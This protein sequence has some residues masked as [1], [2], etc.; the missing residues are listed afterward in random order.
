MKDLLQGRFLGHPLHPLLVHFPIALFLLSL[1]LDAV[2]ILIDSNSAWVQAAFW[3]LAFGVGM[4]LLASVPGWIDFLDI[5]GDHPA[6]RLASTH[7]ILNL[8][9]VGLYS[10]SLGFRAATLQASQ[11]PWLPFGLSMVAFGLIAYSGHLGGKMI[12]DDGVA[13]GRHRRRAATRRDTVQAT[14]IEDDWFVVCPADQLEEGPSLRVRVADRI[15]VVAKHED[16]LY[17]LQEFCT[18]RFGPLSEGAFHDGQV[19]CPWHRSCFGLRSGQ[20]T[21]GPAK[22]GLKTYPAEVRNNLIM[23]LGKTKVEKENG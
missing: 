8:T 21:R 22:M 18:H 14:K 19:E 6:E 16:Q 5:R 4:A 2:T 7:M 12:Y 23:V 13:V 17:A 9:A 1:V 15:L 11:T 10:I 20:V 3:S